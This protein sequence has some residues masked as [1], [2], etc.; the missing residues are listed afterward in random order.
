MS[1]PSNY[2]SELRTPFKKVMFSTLV[3]T[4]VLIC[5][6]NCNH[7]RPPWFSCK[8]PL[9]GESPERW[10]DVLDTLQPR[11]GW[12]SCHETDGCWGPWEYTV[13]KV[14]KI[15]GF[16]NSLGQL[17]SVWKLI[18]DKHLQEPMEIGYKLDTNWPSKELRPLS[19]LQNSVFSMFKKQWK[20]VYVA[21]TNSC[22]LNLTTRKRI[23]E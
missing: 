9:F 16:L 21:G 18:G 2:Y 1:K 17:W 20:S 5:G 7:K 10:K 12:C 6:P 15:C 4:V 22:E 19:I 8:T 14:A 23:E 13:R 11:R 3:S